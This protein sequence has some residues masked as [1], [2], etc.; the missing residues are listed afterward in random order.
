MALDKI[1]RYKD[2]MKLGYGD[3]TS[4]WRKWHSGE[5]PVPQQILGR[6]GWRESVL[7]EYNENCPETNQ[8]NPNP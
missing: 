6:P 8:D 1:Y 5:F 3:R 2:L 4:I 7:Q